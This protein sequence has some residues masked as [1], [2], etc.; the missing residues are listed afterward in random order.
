MLGAI[1]GDIAGSTFE[2]CNTH[3]YNFPLF[4][5]FSNFTDDSICTV[6]VAE[7]LLDDPNLSHKVLR[8]DPDG[9]RPDGMRF[10]HFPSAGFASGTGGIGRKE[11]IGAKHLPSR[12]QWR[13]FHWSITVS[14]WNTITSLKRPSPSSLDWATW[15]M[16]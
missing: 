10:F 16:V 5:L 6:A 7:W 9:G 14:F 4:D 2:F 3:D 1:I 12:R 8:D 15:S 13:L 11:G